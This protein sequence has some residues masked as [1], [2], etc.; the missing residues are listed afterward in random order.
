MLQ[1]LEHMLDDAVDSHQIGKPVVTIDSIG[2][3]GA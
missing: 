1:A 3:L 2:R